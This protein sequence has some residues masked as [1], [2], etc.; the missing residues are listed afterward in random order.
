MHNI[1]E[2]LFLTNYMGKNQDKLELIFTISEN[3]I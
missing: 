3:P 1:E 2:L